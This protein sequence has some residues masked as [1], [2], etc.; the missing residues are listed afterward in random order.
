MRNNMGAYV[1]LVIPTEVIT[2][3]PKPVQQLWGKVTSAQKRYNEARDVLA[4]M[5]EQAKSAPD[6]DA[7]AAR[8]AV[9]KGLPV[10]PST[11]TS[12][13]ES[14]SDKQRE[15][16][17]LADHTDDVEV[18]FLRALHGSRHDMVDGF[19]ADTARALEDAITALESAHLAVDLFTKYAAL[20]NWARHDEDREPPRQGF[21]VP[22]FGGGNVRDLIERSVTALHKEHPSEI[23]AA[24]ASYRAE[25]ASLRGRT[26]PDGVLLDA[27]AYNAYVR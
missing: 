15:I 2:A 1:P 23:E 18:N 11:V 22:V 26:T 27:A 25:M 8:E 6:Q 21:Q 24:E 19:R 13:L 16:K 9:E 10:P 17:A 4:V 14:I 5:E 12:V 20:W 3:S 7:A